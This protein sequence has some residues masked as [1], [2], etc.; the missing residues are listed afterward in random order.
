MIIWISQA[1]VDLGWIM[2]VVVVMHAIMYVDY[3]KENDGG[4]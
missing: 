4:C 3:N 1:I 2:I